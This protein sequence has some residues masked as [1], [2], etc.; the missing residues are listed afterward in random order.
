MDEN[1]DFFGPGSTPGRSF[2]DVLHATFDAMQAAAT[3]A[4]NLPD[5]TRVYLLPIKPALSSREQWDNWHSMVKSTLISHHLQNVI[6]WTKP[7]PETTDVN[8]ENWYN[9]S[10]RV[11]KWLMQCVKHKLIIEVEERGKPIDFAHE[12]MRELTAVVI[13]E[14][15]AAMGAAYFAIE[16]CRQNDYTKISKYLT[17]MRCRLLT[18]QDLG[19]PITPWVVW[20]RVLDELSKIP[21][22]NSD[23]AY[24]RHEMNERENP[25][26][27]TLMQLS[28]Y[29]TML[30]SVIVLGGLDEMRAIDLAGG[31]N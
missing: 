15:N 19:V 10:L 3:Q 6:D 23:L 16:R 2:R 30:K 11:K 24:Y 9:A 14:G 25:T 13:G 5:S 12:F 27:L 21:S 18:A 29:M 4:D 8:A 28:R 20:M 17:E 1:T 7:E 26:D 31:S 22:L